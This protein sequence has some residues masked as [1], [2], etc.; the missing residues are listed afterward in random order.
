[1]DTD[2]A[3]RRP[4]P[5]ARVTLAMRALLE[6][7]LREPDRQR[8]GLDLIKSSGCSSGAPYQILK[9]LEQTGWITGEWEDPRTSRPGPLRKFYTL[10]DL[11]LTEARRVL[12]APPR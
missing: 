7:L 6:E 3:P 4:G 8:Y 9:R 12:K 11:G 2:T 5:Q 10:T 1:M